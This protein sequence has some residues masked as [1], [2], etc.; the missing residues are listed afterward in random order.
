MLI[1]LAVSLLVAQAPA[2]PSADLPA[3]LWD[4]R[5]EIDT[6]A[7]DDPMPLMRKLGLSFM[8]L[9]KLP[10]PQV[11]T[12][13]LTA[14]R[15]SVT[16]AGLDGEKR[17]L[18]PLDGKTPTL[19]DFLGVPFEVVTRVE[20]GAV[21]SSGVLTIDKVKTSFMSRRSVDGDVMRVELTV[22][23]LRSK[24]VFRRLK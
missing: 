20:A 19:G 16:A 21:V 24:R 3:G 13:S 9:R 22:G 1:P 23:D 14:E 18:F 12:T 5:W 11:Q 4:S 6:S 8:Q 15:L 17:Q 10:R 2:T 7:S